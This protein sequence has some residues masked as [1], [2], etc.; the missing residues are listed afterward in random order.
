MPVRI[1]ERMV[2]DA[3]EP[4]QIDAIHS[5]FDSLL[6]ELKKQNQS[7]HLGLSGGRRIMALVGLSAASRYLTPTDQAWHIYTPEDFTE[8]ARDG[9]ILHAPPEAGLRLIAVPFVPWAAYF[10]GL[11]PLLERTPQPL[12]NS[13]WGWL[14]PGDQR[15]CEAVWNRLTNRKKDYLRQMAAGLR[16]PEIAAR[17]NVAVTTV[18]TQKEDITAI[19][20]E[21][22]GWDS[23]EFKELYFVDKFRAYLSQQG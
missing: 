17:L 16:R 1:G 7:I 12:G 11:A 5:T 15:R 13:T 4:A 8:R 9:A 20:R 14:D 19:C 6:S 18:D 21:V 3:F 23:L 22:W 10:P 2:N